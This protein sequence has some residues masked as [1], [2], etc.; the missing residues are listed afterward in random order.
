MQGGVQGKGSYN[1]FPFVFTGYTVSQTEE[2][3]LK[4]KGVLGESVTLPLKIP[5]GKEIEF[6]IWL[7]NGTSIMVLQPKENESR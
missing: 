2:I 4:V 5:A 1:S 6:I 7:L 3:P